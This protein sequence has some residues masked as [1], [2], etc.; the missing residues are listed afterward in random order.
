MNHGSSQVVITLSLSLP[1]F[2]E[3][4]LITHLVLSI[5]VAQRGFVF[6]SN[7]VVACYWQRKLKWVRKSGTS[8]AYVTGSTQLGYEPIGLLK[9]VTGKPLGKI[10]RFTAP[11]LVLWWGWRK[12][13]FSTA[14]ELP[15]G[16]K[17]TGSCMSIASKENLL[18]TTFHATPRSVLFYLMN[19]SLWNLLF[20]VITLQALKN[21]YL[22]THDEPHF[23]PP[24]LQWSNFS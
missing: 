16:R 4:L 14:V 20:C 11:K 9:L 21:V 24:D 17:V 23:H 6:P 15:R 7:F 18:T 1:L 12:P 19:S 10:E 5:V 13:W 2:I 8:S 3:L 22:F